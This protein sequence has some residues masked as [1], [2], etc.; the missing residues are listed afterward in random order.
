MTPSAWTAL[1][2]C[3][4]QPLID[5]L[6]RLPQLAIVE[7][8]QSGAAS[9]SALATKRQ[10]H[11]SL[12][13]TPS[14]PSDPHGPPS[15]TL[16]A[17]HSLLLGLRTYFPT[18][19]HHNHGDTLGSDFDHTQVRPHH[20]HHHA[21][22]QRSIQYPPSQRIASHPTVLPT[23]IAQTSHS[24][25]LTP[26]SA[27]STAHGTA[28]G[29]SAIGSQTPGHRDNRFS[30]NASQTPMPQSSVELILCGVSISSL[31]E[32]LQRGRALLNAICDSSSGPGHYAEDDSAN[33]SQLLTSMSQLLLDMPISPELLSAL[34]YFLLLSG[35]N[36]QKDGVDKTAA[37]LTE[38]GAMHHSA[39]TVSF[40]SSEEHSS[41]GD[42]LS[43]PTTALV[44]GTES[45]QS[46]SS[47]TQ[48]DC[49][50]SSVC[51]TKLSETSCGGSSSSTTYAC[52]S[53]SKQPSARPLHTQPSA[54]SSVP[55]SRAVHLAFDS[56]V[57]LQGH[58]R[59]MEILRTQSRNCFFHLTR[60]QLD[61][62]TKQA[63]EGALTALAGC[64]RLTEVD[65]KV[66]NPLG[67]SVNVAYLGA[68]SMA[69][70]A[71]LPHL[72]VLMLQG[73]VAMTTEG[74]SELS[75]ARQLNFLTLWSSTPTTEQQLGMLQGLSSLRSLSVASLSLTPDA[76]AYP[77]CLPQINTLTYYKVAGAHSLG[78][79][80][81]S[82]TNVSCRDWPMVTDLRLAADMPQLKSLTLMPHSKAYM[83]AVG[84]V[85]ANLDAL[86]GMKQLEEL[87]LKHFRAI[88]GLSVVVQGCSALT[89][90]TSLI[91]Q[92]SPGMSTPIRALQPFVKM[93]EGV[94][95][96]QK[97]AIDCMGCDWDVL[98]SLGRA[99]L[100]IL[101]TLTLTEAPYVTKARV[102]ALIK[103]LPRLHTLDLL[104]C[105][106][107]HEA[108]NDSVTSLPAQLGRPWLTVHFVA[109]RPQYRP[110]GTETSRGV[111]LLRASLKASLKWI[112]PNC[113]RV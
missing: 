64:E 98:G 76:A 12:G 63:H 60:L 72:Q 45:V 89:A 58:D 47:G 43:K 29:S 105:S 81:P 61:L 82:M 93:F 92:P 50:I 85:D 65:V 1:S 69:T 36:C 57:R 40:C 33:P 34:A 107:S 42:I 11:R 88:P 68:S 24:S 21:H 8:L 51:S 23:Q 26:T 100:P 9:C 17:L 16:L 80:F 49:Y 25:T 67:G 32:L 96:L 70:L 109:V 94:T 59:L 7:V 62:T 97:L 86:L 48:S 84:I 41:E 10:S 73:T 6:P 54:R 18:S 55:Q 44:S 30:D 79:V 66:S 112:T 75:A 46:E 28:A 91:L 95:S 20:H 4:L 27:A 110:Q 56:R 101:H 53:A 37:S 39:S 111:E 83:A 35:N 5:A 106:A 14:D 99:N 31:P 103:A 87:H 52:G 2:L 102:R 74:Y 38:V 108:L 13:R 3:E 113:L 104:E 77:T 19:H 15:I 22:Q 78:A 71:A 90:L